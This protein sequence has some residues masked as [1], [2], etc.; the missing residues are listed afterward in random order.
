MQDPAP[1]YL[2]Q[3]QRDRDG[4]LIPSSVA[5]A[6]NAVA[7]V[8][9]KPIGRAV[10]LDPKEGCPRVSPRVLPGLTALGF[11]SCSHNVLI[12][13]QICFQF[14]LAPLHIGAS[15]AAAAAAPAAPLTAVQIGMAKVAAARAAAFEEDDLLAN[16]VGS[17]C[18]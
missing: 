7:H 6:A 13:H 17:G 11:S 2:K 1:R 14:R 10:Q 5:A 15:S 16:M 9:N 12:R 18:S 8:Y 3:Q 4:A